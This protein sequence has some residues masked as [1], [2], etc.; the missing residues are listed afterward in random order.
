MRIPFVAGNWKMNGDR[1][2]I[3]RLL[4]GIR[5]AAEPADG[6]E[7]AVC[8][9]YVYLSEVLQRLQG[10]GIGLGAQDVAQHPPG[11]YTGEVA[12]TMLVDC[13][14][15]FVIVGH[16]E[17]RRL[18]GDTDA[19]VA[20]KTAA[21]LNAGL[22]PIVCVGEQ[23]AEREAGR[24][25]AVIEAQLQ[26]IFSVNALT[27]EPALVIAYEPVWAIGTGRTATPEQA[28]RVH[29]HIRAWLAARADIAARRIRIIYGGSVTAE[30][31]TSLLAMPNVDGGLIGG[32]ALKAD[33]F[34]SICHAAHHARVA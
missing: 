33:A 1:Q 26:A 10:T 12:A 15:R 22:A 34:V 20:A 23:L 19:V 9:P 21:A 5:A 13:G 3:A 7:I 29:A 2:S 18:F 17:R 8:P 27:E 28:E 31:A 30:N 6:A 14:C 11:A 24:T 4:D 32:A 16:S 25:L